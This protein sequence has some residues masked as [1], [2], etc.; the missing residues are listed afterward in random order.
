MVGREKDIILVR[1]GAH[2]HDKPLLIDQRFSRFHPYSRGL[3]PPRPCAHHR[4]LLPNVL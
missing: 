2:D 4:D 3:R 1:Y